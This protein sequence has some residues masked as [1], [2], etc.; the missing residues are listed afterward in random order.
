MGIMLWSEIPVY[1]TIQ[2]NNKNTLD[3]A[4]N[5]LAEINIRDQDSASVIIWSMANETPRSDERLEF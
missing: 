5:Q 3:N 4:L 1:W 2:W